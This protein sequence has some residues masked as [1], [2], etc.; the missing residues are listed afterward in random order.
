MSLAE[1]QL[2]KTRFNLLSNEQL[3]VAYI[4]AQN[5]KLDDDFLNMLLD[6]ILQRDI[7]GLLFETGSKA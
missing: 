4:N 1:K 5:Q 6:E 7:Y 3:I 2:D